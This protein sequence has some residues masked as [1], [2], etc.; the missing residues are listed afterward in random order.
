MWNAGT[1]PARMIEIIS[2][3]GFENFFRDL[4]DLTAAGPLDPAAI[5]PIPHCLGWGCYRADAS[6]GRFW[7]WP[8]GRWSPWR[9][10][11]MISMR[12]SVQW[13]HR[14]AIERKIRLTSSDPLPLIAAPNKVTGS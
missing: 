9:W 5:H 2:P 1:V 12:C 13:D 4:T 10:T 8:V 14:D 6:P 11:A 3:A 7:L